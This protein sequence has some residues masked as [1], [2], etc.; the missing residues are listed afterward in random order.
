[1]KLND[2]VLKTTKKSNAGFVFSKECLEEIAEEYIKAKIPIL[3]Q[4]LDPKAL[5]TASIKLKSGVLVADMDIDITEKELSSF[6]PRCSFNVIK[7]DIE[8]DISIA[9]E[10]KVICIYLSKDKGVYTDIKPL[11]EYGSKKGSKSKK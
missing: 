4:D 7:T 3:S 9:N 6:Y 11:N 5:G 8:K 2:V 1:M 10:A